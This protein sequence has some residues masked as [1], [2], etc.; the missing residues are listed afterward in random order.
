[1]KNFLL[2]L[3]L[4]L[5]SSIL[6]SHYPEQKPPF[7]FFKPRYS[8]GLHPWQISYGISCRNK[9]L[10]KE[11]L[12]E[13]EAETVSFGRMLLNKNKAWLKENNFWGCPR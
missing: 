10:V 1:M 5:S 9:R 2:C 6:P 3:I 11:A 7:L 4:L 8:H 12:L 13:Q